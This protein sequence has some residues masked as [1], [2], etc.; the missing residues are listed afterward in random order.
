MPLSLAPF[1]RCHET[2]KQRL[3]TIRLILCASHSAVLLFVGCLALGPTNA[4]AGPEKLILREGATDV[5]LSALQKNL[6]IGAYGPDGK[7]KDTVSS[8]PV[9]KATEPADEDSCDEIYFPRP[10][11]RLMKKL[12]LVDPCKAVGSNQKAWILADTDIQVI[13]LCKDGQ[14]VA[15]YDFSMGR[16]GTGKTT[17]GDRKTPLGKYALAKPYK[18]DKF[19]VFI[20]IGYPTAAQSQ[21]GMTGADVGIHGPARPFRCAGFLNA[22]VNWTQ[23]CLAV[24]SDTYIKDIGRFV[25]LNNVRELT[26]SPVPVENQK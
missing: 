12:P 2:M 15:D 13:Y 4:D 16:G 3:K 22:A 7:S 19:K 25:Q 21:Q 17:L 5:Q 14:S 24:S 9:S 23:G 20:P 11:L 1:V 8:G 18:S 10:K 26:I 6:A